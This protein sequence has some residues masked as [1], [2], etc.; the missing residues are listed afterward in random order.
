MGQLKTQ[1]IVKTWERRFI[2]CSCIEKTRGPMSS[3]APKCFVRVSTWGLSWNKGKH[4]FK[5][6]WPR[7]VVP[8]LT[9]HCLI[10]FSPAR[11]FDKLPELKDIYFQ[12]TDSSSAGARTSP[13]LL[14]NTKFMGKFSILST[15]I[16]KVQLPRKEHK[17][18]FKTSSFL[19]DSHAFSWNWGIYSVSDGGHQPHKVRICDSEASW[20][21]RKQ[22]S[23]NFDPGRRVKIFT[24]LWKRRRLSSRHQDAIAI[25]IW[26]HEDSIATY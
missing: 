26:S 14:T 20:K 6:S 16:S 24:W 15:T 8:A 23:Y 4:I 19:S 17:Y 25:W 1:L 2:P 11:W 7:C 12:E 13:L 3:L 9:H 10:S 22:F 18:L 5:Q 21:L